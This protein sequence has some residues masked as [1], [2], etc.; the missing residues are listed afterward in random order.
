MKTNRIWTIP[1]ELYLCVLQHDDGT[2]KMVVGC[3]NDKADAEH[4]ADGSPRI[5]IYKHI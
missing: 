3:F 1:K 4:Y 2:F 5:V